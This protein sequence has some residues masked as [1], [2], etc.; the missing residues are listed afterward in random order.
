[1]S[2]TC[3]H[4]RTKCHQ[5]RIANPEISVKLYEDMAISCKFYT[6]VLPLWMHGVIIE[7]INLKNFVCKLM[8]IQIKFI[9]HVIRKYVW[10]LKVKNDKTIIF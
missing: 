1:M 7:F 9:I 3:L 4:C 8:R 2:K 6:E 10:N 5:Y